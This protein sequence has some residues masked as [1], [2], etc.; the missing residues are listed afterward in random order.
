MGAAASWYRAG[1]VKIGHVYYDVGGC[2]S[3]GKFE[4]TL[5]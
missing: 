1:N 5:K 4:K 2:Q 3:K